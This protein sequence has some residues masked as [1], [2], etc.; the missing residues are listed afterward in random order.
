M[1]LRPIIILLSLI[2]LV[3]FLAYQIDLAFPGTLSVNNAYTRNTQSTPQEVGSYDVL[4]KYIKVSEVASLL[5]TPEG[6][7]QLRAENGAV[8]V[9]DQKLM[10]FNQ[11][12]AP[13]Y[14]C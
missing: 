11:I 9:T 13:A 12:P 6:R 10:G 8:A 2:F 7:E 14:K 1:R 3:G 4:G 5:Q